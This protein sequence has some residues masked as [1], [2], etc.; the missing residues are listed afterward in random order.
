MCATQRLSPS[1]CWAFLLDSLGSVSSYEASSLQT[2]IENAAR[3]LIDTGA[4]HFT[5]QLH[6]SGVLRHPTTLV[7]CPTASSVPHTS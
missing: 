7:R 2:A 3:K 5:G 1:S 4:V 6:A